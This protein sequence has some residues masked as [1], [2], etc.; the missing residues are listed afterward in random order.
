MPPGSVTGRVTITAEESKVQSPPVPILSIQLGPNGI[1]FKS[2]ITLSIPYDP[3]L[4]QQG[5]DAQALFILVHSDQGDEIHLNPQSATG[6]L[7]ITTLTHF[8]VVEVLFPRDYK[9]FKQPQRLI[10]GTPEYYEFGITRTS[11]SSGAITTEYHPLLGKGPSNLTTVVGKGTTQDLLSTS[12]GNLLFIHGVTQSPLGFI[13]DAQGQLLNDGILQF[14]RDLPWTK[15]ISLYQYPSGWT[16]RYNA[17]ALAD[18]IVKNAKPGC[19]FIIIAHSM[20][21]LVARVAIED[22]GLAPYVEALITIGTPHEG[23]K[24]HNFIDYFADS[25]VAPYLSAGLIP[26]LGDILPS[27][28]LLTTLNANFLGNKPTQT[29]YYCIAGNKWDQNGNPLNH[30]GLVDLTSAIPAFMNIPWNQT[31]IVQNEDHGGLIDNAR[32]NGVGITIREWVT[33]QRNEGPIVDVGSNQTVAINTLVTLDGSKTV[34]PE[35]DPISYL[36]QQTGWPLTA[37]GPIVVT[38]SSTTSAKATFMAT[39]AGTYEFELTASDPRA[40]NNARMTVTVKP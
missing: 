10:D 31:F 22:F 15:N 38:L 7:L 36:W 16:V 23:G 13:F 18:L 40:K 5:D 6:Q 35:G 21:G 1:Q 27:S 34:D 37:N 32:K 39:D 12:D 2:P 17:K 24:P 8:S 29:Q 11:L 26:G 25:H 14:M 3:K 4:V 9:L 30:D 33:K 20:G 19:R 28:P